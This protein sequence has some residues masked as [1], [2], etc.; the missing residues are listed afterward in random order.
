AEEGIRDRN[1]TGVQTC[2]LPIFTLAFGDVVGVRLVVPLGSVAGVW[3]ADSR[4]LAG[5]SP[6]LKPVE[7]FPGGVSADTGDPLIP[8]AGQV[9]LLLVGQGGNLRG[10]EFLPFVLGDC[11]VLIG[12]HRCLLSRGRGFGR[13]VGGGTA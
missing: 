3:R 5:S 7:C 9:V 8:G 4:T 13:E 12:A 1:V 6:R 11:L 2:A 10:G